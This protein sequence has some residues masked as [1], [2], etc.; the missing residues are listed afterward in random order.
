MMPAYTAPPFHTH[1]F[2]RELQ[3][4]FPHTTARHLMRATR[5]LLVDRI[6]RVRREAVT[7][8][9]L[10]NQAYLFRA[11]ISELRAEITMSTKNDSAAIRTT[12]AALRREVDRLDVKMKEDVGT[13]KHEIQMEL[14]TRKNEARSQIKQQDI[15]IES[16]LNKTVVDCSDLRTLVEEN[17]WEN[18]RRTV[19]TIAV[20]II[21][22]V[23]GMELRPKP[24]P[25]PPPHAPS[26][27]MPSAGIGLLPRGHMDIGQPRGEG[28]REQDEWT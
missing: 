16:L 7:H 13:L 26:M 12:T 18:M 19:T 27:V 15:A 17:K 24:P 1:A 6:G 2:Y 5:A 9:D 14:D 28:E 23:L 22:T 11:A 20:L 10:D 4:T 8:K 25:P 3:K 21:T